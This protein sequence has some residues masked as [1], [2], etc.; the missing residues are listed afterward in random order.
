[1]K[2]IV[3]D[4]VYIQNLVNPC[5]PCLANRDTSGLFLFYNQ[6]HNDWYKATTLPVD[7]VESG[8]GYRIKLHFINE[9][10]LEINPFISFLNFVGY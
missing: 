5:E 3:Q 2:P 9:I 8:L 1:M 7:Q 4:T 10:Y 6:K